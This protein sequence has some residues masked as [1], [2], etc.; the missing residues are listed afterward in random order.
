L[1][2]PVVPEVY[3]IVDSAR[4]DRHGLEG[5]RLAD[6]LVEGQRTRQ[7]LAPERDGGEAGDSLGQRG[8]ELLAAADQRLRAA[9]ARDIG[10][11]GRSQHD[12]DRVD[13]RAGLER[14]VV[15]HHPLPRVGGVEGDAV[16]RLDTELHQAG[17]ERI[18]EIVERAK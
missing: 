17:S 11:L 8:R 6:E 7:R 2:W 9:V 1:G 4:V 16:A 13:H 12:V 15:A 10:D 3:A 5:G 18:R 14:A